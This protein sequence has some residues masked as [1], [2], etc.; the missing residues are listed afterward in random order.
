MNR[1]KQFLGSALAL[2]ALVF[3]IGTAPAQASTEKP[4]PTRPVR[5]VVPSSAGGSLDIVARYFAQKLSASLGTAVVVDNRAG[6]NGIIGMD[7]VAKAVPDGYTLLISTG[8]FTANG[9]LYKKL[10]FSPL[11]D[12]AP[13]T[14]VARSYGLV[15]V[16]NKDI[17]AK[18]VKDLIKVARG[19]PDAMNY[20]SSGEGSIIHL[21]GELFNHLAGTNFQHVPYKGSAP[22]LQDVI[23]KQISMTFVST[24]GGLAAIKDG[25]VR[26]LAIT[27]DVRAPVL[28]NV[29]TFSEE[30]FPGMSAISGWYGLWLPAGTP[31]SIVE[32]TYRAVASF[33]PTT[34][35][36]QRFDELGLITVGISPAEFKRFLEKDTEQQRRLMKL[37]GVQPQ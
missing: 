34:S 19:N 25:L 6:A 3:T 7:V 24:S 22:A 29:P 18:T 13:V 10:P 16:V 1:W 12:F 26:P 27:S 28:P 11:K 15:M 17:P 21:G 20:G 4:W 14:Q 35:V 37:S 9:V 32:R 31:Q 8:A 36:R 33:L 23:S 30:G 5:L 2:G